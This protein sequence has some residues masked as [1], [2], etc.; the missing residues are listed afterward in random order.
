MLLFLLET[1]DY[2]SELNI[3]RINENFAALS[4]E[5]YS[6]K[7]LRKEIFSLANKRNTE[8]D[9]NI[10]Q[11]VKH[12]LMKLKYYNL[13]DDTKHF[14]KTFKLVSRAVANLEKVSLKD[15]MKRY[16]TMVTQ[17]A[18]QLDKKIEPLELDIEVHMFE[19][20]FYFI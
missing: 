5:I 19:K 8:L 9:K 4:E 1:K 20:E 13:K 16:D 3:S 15:Y 14:D 7:T 11:W 6:F 2:S 17:L 12:L 18:K 10:I